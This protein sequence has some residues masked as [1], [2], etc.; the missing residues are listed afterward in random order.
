MNKKN[1]IITLMIIS[2]I[3]MPLSVAQYQPPPQPIPAYQPA[4]GTQLQQQQALQQSLI[5][6]SLQQQSQFI[7]QQALLTQQ[8]G[9]SIQPQPYPQTGLRNTQEQ[10]IENNQSGSTLL[11]HEGLDGKPARLFSPQLTLQFMETSY[12]LKDVAFLNKDLG[13]AVGSP[14]W[15]QSEKKFQGTILKTADGGSSWIVQDVEIT[16]TYYAVVFLNPNL[17]WV[18][19]SNGTVLHT[20]D[21]GTHWILQPVNTSDT[22]K[23]LALTDPLNGWATSVRAIHQDWQGFDDDWEA[24]VWH[25]SNGGLNWTRQILP[26]NASIL[27]RIDFVDSRSGWA[28]GVKKLEHDEI[29]IRHAGVVYCTKDGGETWSEQYTPGQDITLTAVDFVDSLNGWVAGFPTSSALNGGFVFH[30]S[31]GGKNWE[32]QEPGGFFDPLWDIQFIDQKKG[33]V[34]G[35][36]DIAA[37]GPPVWRTLDG[38]ASWTKI[39]MAKGNPLSVLMPEGFFA[40]ALI[41]DKAVLVGDHDLVARSNRAWDACPEVVSPGKSCYNCDCLF[42][43][44]YI[45]PHYML[46]DVFFA[47]NNSGWAAGSRSLVPNLW[48]QVIM[49]T[50]DGGRSWKIQYEQAPPQDK[51]FSYHRLNSICFVDPQNGWAVGTSETFWDPN[52]A[53]AGNWEHRGAILHTKNGGKNWVEEG[54][55]LYD[56]WDLEFFAVKFLNSREGW[57]LATKRFPSQN[58]FL[59]HSLDSGKHW[60]W[61]DTGISGT[62]AVGYALVQGDLEIVDRNN[63]WAAGGLGEVIHSQDGGATWLRQNLSCGYPTCPVRCFALAFQDNLSGWVAGEKLFFT[64]N[65]GYN[66]DPLNLDIEGDIQDFQFINHQNGWLV[67]EKGLFKMTTDGGMG[68]QDVYRGIPMDLRG[69]FFLNPQQGWVVGDYGIIL[70]ANSG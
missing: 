62:I 41:D 64:R 36:N 16:E 58:I 42:E 22:F 30:T 12:Y 56:Q 44:S 45:S 18:A 49:H 69:L 55:N 67:G 34:V 61:V 35:F 3:F 52:Q 13:W 25:T 11:D 46:Q 4:I 29:R 50:A 8:Q 9:Q 17:G 24:A 53:P 21:G 33:Y 65:S 68:W 60:S 48:H 15:N 14:H 39:R 5:Q 47:D 6:Q 26:D 66:W 20:S 43:Q 10:I 51:L 40:L 37:W 19:G 23:G 54:S 32:R 59:A 27:N 28:V 2:I 31:D 7:Q 57:A 63:I 70:N 1:S 38:G